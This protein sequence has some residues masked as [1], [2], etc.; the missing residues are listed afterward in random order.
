MEVEAS[1]RMCLDR[2][3]EDNSVLEVEKMK[4]SRLAKIKKIS[5]N[6]IVCVY[7]EKQKLSVRVCGGISQ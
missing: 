7:V 4:I 6:P 5:L 1:K 3:G 2:M